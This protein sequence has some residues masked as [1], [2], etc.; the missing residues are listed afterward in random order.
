ME[1]FFWNIII[2]IEKKKRRNLI[3]IINRKNK[4]FSIDDNIIKDFINIENRFFDD[5]TE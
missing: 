2:I 4:N 5:K 1:Y 3:Y